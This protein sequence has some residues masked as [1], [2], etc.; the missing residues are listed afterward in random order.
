MT[1]T[2]TTSNRG[3]ATVLPELLETPKN[4]I[5][6]KK[7]YSKAYRKVRFDFGIIEIDFRFDY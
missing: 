5:G 6:V 1:D 3:F 4:S 7:N 2:K